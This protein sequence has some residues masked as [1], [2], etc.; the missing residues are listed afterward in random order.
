M[1]EE[2]LVLRREVQNFVELSMGIPHVRRRA[3]PGY[4]LVRDACNTGKVRVVSSKSLEIHKFNKHAK[5]V[6]NAV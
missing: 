5:T 4:D 3:G 1:V 2:V 6:L